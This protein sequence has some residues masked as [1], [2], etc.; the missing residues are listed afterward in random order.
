MSDFQLK[1]EDLRQ[2]VPMDSLSEE[3][4]GKL[5]SN[6]T[7]KR[8][9]AG[10]ALFR[11]G[12]GEKLAVYLLRGEARLTD[13]GDKDRTVVAG[14]DAARHALAPQFPRTVDGIAASECDVII[15]DNELLDILITW[16][17]SAGY[18]VEEISSES[19]DDDA[20][21]MTRMLSSNLF[22][23]IPPANIQAIFSKMEQVHAKKGEAIIEQGSDGDY[24]YIMKSGRAEVVRTTE[25]GKEMRLAEKSV[26]DGFGEEA[27]ISDTKRN[28]TVRM[29]TEGEL[30]R[31]AKEDFRALLTEPVLEQLSFEEAAT[32]VLKQKGVWVDVR[33]ESE[34]NNDHIKGA[35]NVPLYLLRIH[36]KKL[37]EDRPI[38]VYCDT[39]RRSSAAA[40][41]LSE[42]G[43]DVYVLQGGYQ[44]AEQA[45]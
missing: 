17:Q 42:R 29:L 9:P 16:E 24:Y 23:R 14:S 38:V 40:Y 10:R 6:V 4:M 11:R 15:I 39:G 27:L 18:V 45:A 36:A 12:D 32:M 5:I 31:L 19:V 8:L 2:F 25:I 41:L 7:V 26:G 34:F 21:W 13:G 1:P 30:M 35:I 3:S 22:F 43:F 28:A 33:L 44:A 20:D 37:P